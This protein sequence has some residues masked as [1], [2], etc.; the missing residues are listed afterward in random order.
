MP[1]TFLRAFQLELMVTTMPGKLWRWDPNKDQ[2]YRPSSF[3]TWEMWRC[4]VEHQS[5]W[6]CPLS[7]GLQAIPV[8]SLAPKEAA[9][10]RSG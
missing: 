3:D 6:Q 7:T 5:L 9:V 2:E 8:V 10:L 1:G 4:V